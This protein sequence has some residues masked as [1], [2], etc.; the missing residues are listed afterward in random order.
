MLEST[1][2]TPKSKRSK[3]AEI[4]SKLLHNGP[5]TSRNTPNVQSWWNWNTELYCDISR[6]IGIPCIKIKQNSKFIFE[7]SN[8]KD[9]AKR[10]LY[11]IEI[12]IDENGHGKLGKCVLPNFINVHDI[13]SQYPVDDLNNVKYFLKSCKH[14]IDCYFSRL[15]QVDELKVIKEFNKR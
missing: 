5:T 13:L 1:I 8:A 15:K 2:E 6:F 14:H 9:I 7:M 4:Q 3:L 11:A 10:N 12:L